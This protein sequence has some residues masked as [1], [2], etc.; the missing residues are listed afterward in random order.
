MSG[1]AHVVGPAGIESFQS[2][3]GE[4]V[5]VRVSG[6]E[7]AGAYDILELTIEPG[8]GVTPMHVHHENDEAMYVLEGEL[9][10]QL[11][12]DQHVLPPGAYAIAPRGVP[13]TYRN[14]GDD[15]ARVLFINSP[16]NNWRYLKAAAEHGPVEDESDIEAMLPILESYG[17][18]MVGPPLAENGD[19][20]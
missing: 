16:G 12:D 14:S 1:E 6:D 9:T 20:P 13:H 2:P 17:V 19:E 10:V 7:S 3:A 5:V 18:E 11:G 8:P 15:I 4:D